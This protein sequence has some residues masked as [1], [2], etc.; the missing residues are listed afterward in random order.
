MRLAESSARPQGCLRPPKLLSS[1][2]HPLL[3]P[4]LRWSTYAPTSIQVTCYDL[5]RRPSLSAA[6][7][8]QFLRPRNPYLHRRI[9]GQP[10]REGVETM[11]GFAD[12]FRVRKPIEILKAD[13]KRQI[14]EAALEI[15]ETVG[16]RIT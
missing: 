3:E 8:L 12:R 14:H 5:R 1:I 7:P 13:A 15:M 16:V 2:A 10:H 9:A 11:G 6:W 4:P